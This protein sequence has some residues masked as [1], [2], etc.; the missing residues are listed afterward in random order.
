MNKWRDVDANE[1]KAVVNNHASEI[2]TINDTKAIV[3]ISS[4]GRLTKWDS[5]AK[6]ITDSK[7]VDGITGVYT[8][9]FSGTLTG[10]RSFSL[11]DNT[12]EILTDDADQTVTNKSM[13][14]G[15]NTFTNIPKDAVGLDQ[16]DNV[17][18]LPMSYLDT[19]TTLAANS[20]SKVASQKAIKAYVDNAVVGLL[21]D[22]GSYDASSNLF[23]SSGGSG[24]AGAVL[25][26]D[27]W[28]ISVAGTLGG[29]SVTVG[30][31]IRALSDSPGQTSSNWSIIEVNIQYVPENSA[32]KDTDGT[33]AANSDTKYASQKA[34]KTYADSLK[35]KVEKLTNKTYQT[36]DTAL[37]STAIDWSLG[38]SFSRTLSGNETF[39]FSNDT[40]GQTIV[41]AIKQTGAGGNTATW[42][43]GILW[44][45]GYAPT[46]TTT[47]N[48]TDVFTFIKI[49]GTIYGS[50]VQNF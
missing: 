29:Q 28:F 32:N 23:P 44:S 10:H 46:L 35:S 34:V 39:T 12:G 20:D 33:L 45:G 1:V 47:A 36:V 24:T 19:D 16:V 43:G 14:G 42:P 48:K 9:T 11:P 38:N 18:Q 22:R 15:A 2:D 5:T 49:N 8:A 41:V 50:A 6:V 7:F 37:A 21:D 3:G 31:S 30:D 13:D 4:N 27:M 17:Q 40:N 26:G 25:K